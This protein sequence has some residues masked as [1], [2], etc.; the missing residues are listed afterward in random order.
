[1]GLKVLPIGVARTGAWSY[2]FNYEIV[3][4][5]FPELPQQAR[6]IKRS[7]ARPRIALPRHCSG[8]RPQDDRQGDPHPQMDADR[9]GTDR[10]GTNETG[11]RSR[12][13][14]HRKPATGFGPCC[15]WEVV[16]PCLLSVDVFWTLA[17]AALIIP[18]STATG[19]ISRTLPSE[20]SS[21]IA[22]RGSLPC[23]DAWPC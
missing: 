19:S 11:F 20:R 13:S 22:R 3:Q 6:P 14:G 7:E 8:S 17:V 15:G 9:T 1:V 2:A 4:R 12:D 23:P 21:K 10:R 16:K 5:H 18:V